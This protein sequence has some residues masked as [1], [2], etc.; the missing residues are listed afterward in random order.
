MSKRN[1][2]KIYSVLAMILPTLAM[3]KPTCTVTIK[4]APQKSDFKYISSATCTIKYYDYVS[5]CWDDYSTCRNKVVSGMTSELYT[6]EADVF[7][8]EEKTEN[9][10]EYLTFV[11]ERAP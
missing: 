3:A 7:T 10:E 2:L 11:A 5:G 9:R 8:K 4:V 6:L 1:I